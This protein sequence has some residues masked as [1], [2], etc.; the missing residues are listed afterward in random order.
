MPYDYSYFYNLH[1]H[2]MGGNCTRPGP[3][4]EWQWMILG[5]LQPPCAFQT[6]DSDALEFR[7]I[8]AFGSVSQ[9]Y[10]LT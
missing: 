9:Y 2:E 4:S 8:L 7:L 1:M 10:W 6:W 3:L 5:L